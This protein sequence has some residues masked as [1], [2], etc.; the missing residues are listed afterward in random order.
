MR[1]RHRRLSS[2]KNGSDS[3]HLEM[4]QQVHFDNHL[5]ESLA[6]T[7]HLPETPFD[8]GVVLAHCFT[9]SRHTTLLRE[10]AR[11]LA[12]AGIAALRF[13]FSGNGQS[14]GDFAQSTH[15]KQIVEVTAAAD[16]LS[17]KG[18][19]WLGLAGH[20]MGAV[21]ALLAAA[22]LSTVRAVCCL[23]GRLSGMDAS[24]YL[25]LDQR[26]ELEQSGRTAFVSRGRELFL[27]LD[28]FSDAE[29]FDPAADLQGLKPPLLIVHGDADEIVPVSEAYGAHAQKSD[30]GKLA[31]IENADH[32][33]SNPVHRIAICSTVV[34]WFNR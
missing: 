9:C 33:F 23:A 26:I 13:D 7:L 16:F 18:V 6:G 28:F 11:E 1:G 5:G 10:I 32:M 19:L 2:G 22:R 14:D 12:A 29:K 4:E 34:D 31:I 8:R 21:V 17:E 20:S 30:G 27:T 24:R 25:T 15:T 3:G